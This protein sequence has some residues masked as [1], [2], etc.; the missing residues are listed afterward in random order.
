M[1]KQAFNRDGQEWQ[2]GVVETST[3]ASPQSPS[4]H[5]GFFKKYPRFLETSGTANRPGRLNLRYEAMIAANH[6]ILEGA[7][8]LDIASHDGRWSFAALKAGARHVTGIEP[9]Q[10][11][12]D[13]ANSTLADYGADPSSYRFICGDGF[14]VLPH[15]DL[16]VDVVLCLGFIYHTLRYPE[17]FRRLADLEPAHLILDTK[18]FARRKPVI[19]MFVN[20]AEQEGHAVSDAFSEGRFT[21][22]GKPSLRA[23]RQMLSVYGFEVANTYDWP[24]LIALNPQVPAKRSRAYLDGTRVT[25]RCRRATPAEREGEDDG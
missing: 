9:R 4:R 24:T 22:V 20:K 21:L 6:D 17:L 23:L 12:V 14:E 7:R 15:E 2:Y 10:H 1:G 25:L 13:N 5:S 11:L 19:R 3:Q 16:D 18:V 8:V